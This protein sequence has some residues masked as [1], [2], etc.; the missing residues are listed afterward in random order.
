MMSITRYGPEDSLLGAFYPG[1]HES[2]L[3]PYGLLIILDQEDD[4]TTNRRKVWNP[5]T[6]R[7]IPDNLNLYNDFFKIHL[8]IS[9]L[10]QSLQTDLFF[11]FNQHVTGILPC[12]AVDTIIEETDKIH[13]LK[14]CVLKT[15]SLII[16]KGN[17][18]VDK[19]IGYIG[20][21]AI[22]LPLGRNK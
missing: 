5:T 9:Q 20:H 8:N 14:F 10:R 13:G 21:K 15:K 7:N 3:Y 2:N 22:T 18:V 16:R 12:M 4:N 1:L 11:P 17:L 19:A 6:P